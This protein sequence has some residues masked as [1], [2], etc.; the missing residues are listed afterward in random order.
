MAEQVYDPKLDT[1]EAKTN[2]N[3]QD[4][5][6][7][8]VEQTAVLKTVIELNS[9][10][11]EG[12]DLMITPKEQNK[13]PL[14]GADLSRSLGLK[15]T[16][17]VEAPPQHVK[18]QKQT[19]NI[20]PELKTKFQS[21]FKNLFSRQGKIKH[22]IVRTKLKKPL[23]AVQQ[24]GCR[25]PIALQDRVADETERLTKGGHI[26]KFRACSEDHS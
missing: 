3:F 4:F 12:A 18:G 22:R 19:S 1:W 11:V 17:A 5:N 10:K 26:R 7:N 14:R 25:V 24:K 13:I 20:N 16:Q 8:P 15:L 9:W 6:G 23:Q 2:N 21:E